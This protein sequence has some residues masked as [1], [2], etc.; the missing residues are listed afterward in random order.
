MS[1]NSLLGP[2]TGNLSA[3][4]DEVVFVPQEEH[5][6]LKSMLLV[7][8][9]DNPLLTIDNLTLTDAKRI[10]RSSKVEKYWSL[11]GFVEWLRNSSEY[12][13]RIERT[14]DLAM[15]AL[16]DILRNTDPKAQGARVSAI[17]VAAEVA[18][19]FP[20]KES[21][22]NPAIAAIGAMDRAQLEIFLQKQGV[23]LQLSGSKG[24]PEKVLEAEI[25]P[26]GNKK[27]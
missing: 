8:L 5:R 2:E 9:V 19:K 17:K 15:T 6:Q 3:L 1:R 16:E 18:N 27:P 11:P 21:Q 12:R 7:R 26:D 14:W 22:T 23:T 13:E 25:L 4:T 20:R 10:L 24:S